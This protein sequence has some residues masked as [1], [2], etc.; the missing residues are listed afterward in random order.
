MCSRPPP[1]VQLLVLLTLVRKGTLGDLLA[2]GLVK[3]WSDSLMGLVECFGHPDKVRA[4]ALKTCPSWGHG[5]EA[6]SRF[7]QSFEGG[8]YCILHLVVCHLR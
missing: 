3:G 7:N 5:V 4:D 2:I 6:C 1:V 8:W